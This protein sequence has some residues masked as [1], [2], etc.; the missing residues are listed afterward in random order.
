MPDGFALAAGTWTKGVHGITVIDFGGRKKSTSI[1]VIGTQPS[2]AQINAL[3]SAIGEATNGTTLEVRSSAIEGIDPTDAAVE[4]Y[5]E[6]YAAV[7]SVGVFVFQDFSTRDLQQIE[8][9]AVDASLFEP[10]GETIDPTNALALAIINAGVAALNAGGAG[11]TFQR[12]F[13][14]GRVQRAAGRRVN[15]PLEEPGIGENPPIGPGDV[16]GV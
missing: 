2:A 7:N 4:L 10:D 11:Y 5:D 14:S 3:R 16:D 1:E 9:P 6:A 13:L 8:V 15:L 12:G